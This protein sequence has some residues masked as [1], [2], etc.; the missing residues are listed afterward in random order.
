MNS[1]KVSR[2]LAAVAAIFTFSISATFAQ[3]D[4]QGDTVACQNEVINYTSASVGAVYEW[5]AYPGTVTGSGDSVNVS[6]TGS[7]SGLV[8]LVVKDAFGAVICTNTLNVMIYDDPNPF[9]IPSFIASC[10]NDSISADQGRKDDECLS[11]CD[12]VWVTYSVLPHAGSTYNW[13]VSGPANVIPSTSN[14][15][16]VFWTAAG[17]GIVKV[18]ETNVYGCTGQ[19]SLC[20]EVVESP[21]ASFTTMPGAVSGTVTA[22]LGQNILFQNTS[23]PASGSPLWTY[24]WVWG[25]GSSD[26]EDANSSSGTISHAYASSGTYSVMMIAE[27][28]CHCKDTAYITVNVLSDP[29]PNIECISTV[30]PGSSVTYYTDD[31]CTGY[32]WSVANGTISGSSSAQ[33]VTVNWGSSAPGYLSLA[34]TGCTPSTCPVTNTVQVPIIPPAATISGPDLICA[35]SCHDYHISCDIPI[36]SIAW[37]FPGGVTVNQDSVN[38][39]DAEVCFYNSSFDTGTIYVEYFHNTPGSVNELSCG[40]TASLFIQQRPSM[41]LFGTAEICETGMYNLYYTNTG[42]TLQVNISDGVSIDTTFNISAAS[43]YS[44]P[45]WLGPGTFTVTATDTNGYYCT[46]EQSVVV[47]VHENPPPATAIVGADTICPNSA[48]TY[49]GVPTS[50][51]FALSWTASNTTGSGTNVG[52]SYPLVWAASGPYQICVIQIDPQT[53][54]KSTPICDTIVSGSPLAPAVVSGPDTVCNNSHAGYSATSFAGSFNW[55]VT[56]SIAGSVITGQG[57]STVTMEWNNWTGLATLSVTAYGCDGDSSVTSYNVLVIGTPP[58]L[59]SLPSTVCE[60]VG[61]VMSSSTTGATFTWDF[62]DG[63]ATTTGSPVTHIYNSPGNQLVTLTAQYTGVCNGSATAT[64]TIMVYPKPNITISTPDPNLFCGPVANVNMFV[65]SPVSGTS[66]IWYKSPSTVVTTGTSYTTNVLGTYYVLGTNS[67]GCTGVSN[68]IVIDT[69]CD[70][71]CRPAAG[72]FVD[73]NIQRIGCNTD[74]FSGSSSAGAINHGY[75]FDDPFGSPSG[76]TGLNASHT[77]PEPG[78]YRITFCADV[79]NN[80]GTG[81]CRICT[82]KV[83]SILYI[84]DFLDSIFC[85]PGTDSLG[86]QIIDNTKILSTAPAPSYAW[87]INSGGTVST[88]SDPLFVLPAGS[89]TITLTVNGVCSITKTIVISGPPSAGFTSTDSIC[90]GSPV[91]LSNA[92]AVPDSTV[93]WDFGDGASSTIYNPV[94][95]Y[96][97]AGNYTIELFVY[98][99]YGCVD[100]ASKTITVLPNTLSAGFSYVPD[101]LCEGDSVY[102]TN[103]TTGG[104]PGYSWLWSTTETTSDITAV[105]TGTYYLEA[106]DSKGCM[107]RSTSVDLLF[108]PTPRPIL[109]GP[110]VICRDNWE[111]LQVNYPSGGYTFTWTVNGSVVPF[112]GNNSYTLVGVAGNYTV[113]VEVSSVMGCVGYDTVNVLIVD[114]PV[115]SVLAASTLCEGEDHLLVGTTT[116][117]IV[118]G[119]F[120]STGSTNDS[121]YASNPAQYTY[122]VIDTFGCRGS[123]ARTIHPLP[124]FCG[125]MT[126]CYEICDTIKELV[127]YA[128][129]GYSAYQWLYNGSPVTGATSDTIHIPLY[130]SGIYQVVMWTSFGCS[131]TSDDIE[132]E[133]K[134]CKDCVMGVKPSIECGPVD[135][136]GNQTYVLTVDVYNDFGPGSIV[137]LYSPCGYFTGT[138]PSVIPLGWTTVTT[139][140]IQNTACDT[141]CITLTL[142]YNNARCDTSF[143]IAIPDC[144]KECEMSVKLQSI[145]CSGFDGSGNPVYLL[146]TDVNWGGSNGSTLTITSSEGSMTPSSVTVNNGLNSL[147]F[148]FVD[149]PAYSNTA[150]FTVYVFDSVNHTTCKDSFKADYKPCEDT[151]TFGVYGLCAHCKDSTDEGQMYNIELTVNNYLG[152]SAI[153][154][155]LPISGGTFGSISPNPV[156]AGMQT[157]NMPFVDEGPRDSII[158]FRI[159]LTTATHTCWQDVCVYLPECDELSVGRMLMPTYFS[160]APN[161]AS[162][163]ISIYHSTSVNSTNVLHIYNA[164]GKVVMEIPLENGRS[165]EE[166]DLTALP[167]GMYFVS[168]TADGQSRGTIKLMKQ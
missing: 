1:H 19:S 142:T 108:N 118:A 92:S 38:L 39:H 3:C 74:T 11:V 42:A 156:P 23:T 30:C 97:T 127:W 113:S 146:C 62:G 46:P 50:S 5:N 116:S 75:S 153:P 164:V 165:G 59:M 115:V 48:Y 136:E 70:T 144:D 124:D 68:N 105:Y 67:Y 63:S 41:N 112:W 26:V 145:T 73:F 37:H 107:D 161:P 133:F 10:S 158:C 58:P 167:S 96:P 18:I 72:S 84:P 152:S 162:N 117:N 150:L 27:N 140:Y 61:V 95:V 90:Q 16:Q 87:S 40:G 43:S 71:I 122:T 66:Y 21:E 111:P 29:A 141:D 56:P 109:T 81:Y 2:K 143:C 31:S 160:I 130:Q 34:T 15:I 121:I 65:A 83:D 52:P 12:S 151:C 9:I 128:P 163:R 102:L 119:T 79:P 14:S 138:S 93:Y 139:T 54:C 57:G 149:L 17:S 106:T 35:F 60:G 154:S 155:V 20:V 91:Y 24:T 168:L 120:W 77:Y 86:V 104:Y 32:T 166:I 4:L 51:N 80:T 126:G 45:W 55:S 47:V 7:G 36:D 6:W 103:T 76:A 22:C 88:S 129:S 85:I 132:I 114:P 157:L 110:T 49:S 100:S 148:T 147:C 8:T 94:K 13:T 69:I 123:A 159:I 134:E 137:N 98:S 89:Y 78:Y 25:D 135:A 125:M 131:D 44:A 99:P 33:Q 82:T 53:G 28:E 64:G 101:S